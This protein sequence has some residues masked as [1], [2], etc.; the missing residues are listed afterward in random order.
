[1]TRQSRI[2]YPDNAPGDFYV[3]CD[4]CIT[5]CAPEQE[6]PDLMGFF[7]DPDGSNAR[8]HCYFARQP[9]TSDEFARAIRA[10]H[11]SCCEA[12]RYR[13]SDR[14]VLRR[15]VQLGNEQS[16]DELA[17]VPIVTRAWWRLARRWS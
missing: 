4:E 10:V 13:G 16:C 8:S 2:A 7:E 14:F 11:V 12:V 5:C 17:R 3:A 9:R 6:A 1:M 15:L